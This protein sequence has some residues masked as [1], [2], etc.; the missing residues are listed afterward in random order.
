MLI[1]QFLLENLHFAINLFASLVFFAVSWLYL[2]AWME[3][4]EHKELLKIIGFALFSLSF[5]VHATYIEQSVLTNAVFNSSLIETA[6][7]IVKLLAFVFLIIG[8]V[9]DPI[10]PKPVYKDQQPEPVQPQQGVTAAAIGTFSLQVVAWA[11]CF[12][13][14]TLAAFLLYLRRATIGL[15]NHLK[16]L[17]FGFFFIFLYELFSLS[18]IFENTS[19]IS[20]YNIVAPF[21]PLWI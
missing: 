13:I 8:L 21:G 10:Q 6:A 15:E 14:L 11:V 3:T 7:N 18:K 9:I 19:T 1:T 5:L 2:D 20:I 4:K 16:P 17:T 12:P